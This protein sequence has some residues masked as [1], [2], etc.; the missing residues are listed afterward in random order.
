MRR[1]AGYTCTDHKTNT[2]IAKELKITPILD[3]LQEYKR[4]THF[5]FSN[6]IS[7]PPPPEIGPFMRCEKKIHCSARQA[8]DGNVIRRMRFA[9]RVTKARIQTH[10]F[11][12]V[13][14]TVHPYNI[15]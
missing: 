5:M 9:C 11:F 6:L 7:P 10:I 2:K 15:V 4:N 3:K 12:Y 14:G 13:H 1:T 8:T